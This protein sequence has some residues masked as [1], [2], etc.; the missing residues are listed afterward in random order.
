MQDLNTN[1][2]R[3]T[4]DTAQQLYGWV[5]ARAVRKS[6]AYSTKTKRVDDDQGVI[7]R[8]PSS[9]GSSTA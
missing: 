9:Q 8:P 5:S 1:M 7:I 3:K 4:I 2:Q 6:Q